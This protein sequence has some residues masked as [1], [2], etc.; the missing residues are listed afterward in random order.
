MPKPETL[1]ELEKKAILIDLMPLYE[2]NEEWPYKLILQKIKEIVELAFPSKKFEVFE[3]ATDAPA[4]E[5]K[6]QVKDIVE[7]CSK[8]DIVVLV[9]EYDNFYICSEVGGQ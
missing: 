8:S 9:S 5:A 7:N 4:E 3:L 1:E 2:K 6:W